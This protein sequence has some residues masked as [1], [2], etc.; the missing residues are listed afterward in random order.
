MVLVKGFLIFTE[1]S[2]F[3]EPLVASQ[4]QSS[5]HMLALVLLN[6]MACR[7]FRLLR[8]ESHDTIYSQPTSLSTLRF[9]EC[10]QEDIEMGDLWLRI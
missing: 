7:V 5:A 10:A 3:F 9:G 4:H 2:P 1:F 6:V 8:L